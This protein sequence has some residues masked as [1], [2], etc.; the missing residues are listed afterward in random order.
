MTPEEIL[1]LPAKHITMIKR[2]FEAVL[3]A[4]APRLPDLPE[5]VGELP[6]PPVPYVEGSS[7]SPKGSESL[8]EVEKESLTPKSISTTTN[9]GIKEA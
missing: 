3:P 1:M 8:G 9:F 4:G 5:V 6:V 7:K 2:Q